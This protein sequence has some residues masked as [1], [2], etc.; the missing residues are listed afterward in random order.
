MPE[1][2]KALIYEQWGM[3]DPNGS[4]MI[5]AMR[6]LSSTNEF[7]H[8]R[9]TF[10][11]HLIGTFGTLAVWRQ[12]LSVRRAGLF[13]TAFSG[14]LFQ[15]FLWDAADASE[16]AILADIIGPEAEHLVWLFG[17]VNRGAICGLS[18][19][20]NG[21]RGVALELSSELAATGA[22]AA[23]HRLDGAKSL[24]AREVANLMVVT[25]AD[26]LEQ[27]V[28]INGWRDHHQVNQ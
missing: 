27:L 13:H 23:R 17:T 19:V 10:A 20:I 5:S 2:V 12:P 3:L 22:V 21:S 11:D 6:T 16:R 7:A 14:D 9:D 15:F 26:Y 4:L 25:V 18:A 1:A 24:S 28:E 8:A